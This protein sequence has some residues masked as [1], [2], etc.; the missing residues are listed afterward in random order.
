MAPSSAQ[1][2]G[3]GVISAEAFAGRSGTLPKDCFAESVK[4][5][6]VHSRMPT[7]RALRLSPATFKPEL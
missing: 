7:G 5:R 2:P 1:R 6:F 4:T 3:R